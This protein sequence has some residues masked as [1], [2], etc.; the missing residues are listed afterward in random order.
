MLEN[1]S[2]IPQLKTLL[3]EG[4]FLHSVGVMQTMA[5]LSE[6][7]SLDQNKAETIGLLHDAAKELTK[8]QF[9]LLVREGNIQIQHDCESNFVYY[10]HGPVG[11]YLVQKEFGV[12]DQEII[13]AIYVHTFCDCGR[14]FNSPL[15]W[16]IRFADLIEPNRDWSKMGWMEDGV[17]E[18]REVTFEGQ[19]K[20][21]ALLHLNLA[22]R[23]FKKNGVTVHP[24]VY[25]CINEFST[26]K[27]PCYEIIH[28]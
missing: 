6:I 27:F 21:A 18:L 22:L 10:L 16:C 8:D 3:T 24:N 17:K 7:Y 25:R 1:E 9:N 14:N 20:K 13:D 2:F 4:R 12:T 11:A 19:F 26:N 5:Q 28:K 23:L 15:S